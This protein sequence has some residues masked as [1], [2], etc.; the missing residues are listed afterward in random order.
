[1]ESKEDQ[2]FLMRQEIQM[3]SITTLQFT[4]RSIK[5]DNLLVDSSVS[6]E[7]SQYLVDSRSM[8][9]KGMCTLKQTL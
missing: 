1:M 3:Y 4:N 6:E 8:K 7:V 9:T 5:M 2:V